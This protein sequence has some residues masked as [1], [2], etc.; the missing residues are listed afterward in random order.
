M[1]NMRSLLIVVPIIAIGCTSADQTATDDSADEVISASSAQVERTVAKLRWTSALPASERSILSHWRSIGFTADNAYL[2]TDLESD[3]KRPYRLRRWSVATGELLA[4]VDCQCPPAR[5]PPADPNRPR[6][7]ISPNGDFAALYLL[8]ERSFWLLDANT[9]KSLATLRATELRHFCWNACAF[10][11]D[12]SWFAFCESTSAQHAV[13]LVKTR[14]PSTRKNFVLGTK[15]PNGMCFSPDSKTLVMGVL[16]KR[17]AFMEKRGSRSCI[18]VDMETGKQRVCLEELAAEPFYLADGR[19]MAI[20]EDYSVPQY[21]CIKDLPYPGS[22]L[23]CF[24][25]SGPT[26]VSVGNSFLLPRQGPGTFHV[27]VHPT[28]EGVIFRAT[29]KGLGAEEP[30]RCH[31]INLKSGEHT[32]VSTPGIDLWAISR[33]GSIGLTI[34][35]DGCLMRLWEWN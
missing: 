29:S 25:V 6:T 23:Q 30:H 34:D 15:F 22:R 8:G 11:P 10:S 16:D 32:I 17:P 18:M 2:F 24:D 28:P 14:E 26:P 27:F 13:C 9:G 4:E 5:C 1:M 20:N 21:G 19:L 35:D 33:D 7:Y 31:K 3:G 12:S